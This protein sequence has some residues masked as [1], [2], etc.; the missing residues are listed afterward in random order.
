MYENPRCK[1]LAR[2]QR[3]KSRRHHTSCVWAVWKKKRAPERF[4]ALFF[5]R[6]CLCAL[7]IRASSKAPF[8][9]RK[10]RKKNKVRGGACFAL[11]A[12]FRPVLSTLTRGKHHTRPKEQA[13]RERKK[14]KRGKKCSRMS[15]SFGMPFLKKNHF[16]RHYRNHTSPAL[17]LS[18]LSLSL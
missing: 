8:F 17:V 16:V 12:G 15:T 2:N 5:S 6:P 18:F 10:S 3:Q 11:Q 1:P 9:F 13:I 4:P 7:Y 14:E